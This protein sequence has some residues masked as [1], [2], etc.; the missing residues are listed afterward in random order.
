[1]KLPQREGTISSAF[2]ISRFLKPPLAL[3][4]LD[5]MKWTKLNLFYMPQQKKRRKIAM[6]SFS[7]MKRFHGGKSYFSRVK[8]EGRG[9]IHLG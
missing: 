2:L 1:M 7:G 9:E 6:L 3:T 5:M 4:L 8:M